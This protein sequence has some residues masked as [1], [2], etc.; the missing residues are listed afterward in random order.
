MRRS[1]TT[2]VSHYAI[3]EKGGFAYTLELYHELAKTYD[4]KIVVPRVWNIYS[5]RVSAYGPNITIQ[6]IAPD[7]QYKDCESS[8][9]LALFEMISANQ[10]LQHQLQA[11]AED[12]VLIICEGW[13]YVPLAKRLFPDKHIIFR[14]LHVEYDQQIWANKYSTLRHPQAYA[15]KVFRMEKLACKS[16]DQ[17]LALTQYDAYRLCSLYGVDK[18][19]IAIL[20]VCFPDAYL[21]ANYLPRE[22]GKSSALYVG[23]CPI[24]SVER[25]V[26]M[27][28][29]FPNIT[30]HI[31]GRV[32]YDLTGCGE[33]VII[34][35]IVSEEEKQSIL[36]NCDFALNLTHMVSGMNTK[37]LDYFSMGIPVISTIEGVR[38]FHMQPGREFFLASYDTI[39]HDLTTF[40]MLRDEERRK[41]A[42]N[43][44]YHLCHTFNY[45][46][47]M[48]IFERRIL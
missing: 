12:S 6:S 43:A 15:E 14:S 9:E 5:D 36:A 3:D 30:F 11:I 13:Y 27:M 2:I 28:N 39:E 18:N 38:G 31:V 21:A 7:Y 29:N 22:R 42:L 33:N 44:F 4:I 41:I 45:S 19:K 26:L 20:P 46:N 8:D 25:F 47:Y 10:A 23:T 17:I 34:H 1:I 32:G 24:D 16:A 37:M 35:G 48:N 40:L